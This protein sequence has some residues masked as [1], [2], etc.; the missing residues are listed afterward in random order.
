MV[1]RSYSPVFGENELKRIA[2]GEQKVQMTIGTIFRVYE[3]SIFIIMTNKKIVAGLLTAL[4]TGALLGVLFAPGKGSKTRRRIKSKGNELAD[5]LK[6]KFTEFV[7]KVEDK[8]TA[9]Q[10]W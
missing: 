2:G 6:E 4:A 9:V 7:D 3:S 5:T 10:R 1:C 8:L